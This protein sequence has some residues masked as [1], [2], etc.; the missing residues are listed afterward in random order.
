MNGKYPGLPRVSFPIVDVREV[1]IAHLE[2]LK[3]SQAANQRFVL[4]NRSLWIKDLADILHAEFSTKGYKI[5]RSE[6]P[7]W[8][9]SVASVF[10]SELK[11][12]MKDWGVEIVFNN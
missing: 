1:A 8:V 12:V 3:R 11:P 9:A 10:L 4:T 7:K 6:L 2:G 5:P